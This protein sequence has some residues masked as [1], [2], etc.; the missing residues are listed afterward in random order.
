MG[1]KD[2]A[3]TEAE[4]DNKLNDES[5]PAPEGKESSADQAASQEQGDSD[6]SLD[7]IFEVLKNSRRREVLHFLR[8]RG[9]Q[10]SLGEL[11]EHVAAIENETTTDALTSSERKR[12]YVG[13]YQ[14]H[15]PKMDDIGVVN[16]NQDRGHI[17]LTEM[18]DDFEK[19]L[20]RSEDDKSDR[21]WYQYYAAV[22]ILGA[23]VLAASVTFSLSGGMVL[24]LFSLV[25]GVAGACSVY[26]WSVER[27]ASESE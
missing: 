24:G 7:V 15:L 20:E 6:A 9:E 27:E 8:E 17:T 2:T 4:P 22:S 11:A 25:V 19:Y 1:V 16:F 18:A 21:Q 12:V 3:Q 14:C 10:V 26:H 5:V 13:L 23:M